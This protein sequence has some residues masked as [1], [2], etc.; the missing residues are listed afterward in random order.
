MR[1]LLLAGRLDLRVEEV[2]PPEPG[3][4]Q[5][6]VRVAAAGVCGSD[7]HGYRGT[8]DRR[9]PGTVMGHEVSGTVADVGP[10][11][12]P[13]WRGRPV[14]LNPVLGCERCPA[15]RSGEPQRCPDKAL[16]G[17]VPHL[18]GGFAE[19]V[20]GPVIALVPWDGPAPLAWGAFAE[21]LAVG[22]H[23]ARRL[24]PPQGPV[25]V[26]RP[27]LAERSVLVVGSGPVALAAAWSAQRDGARVSVTETDERRGSLVRSLGLA[28]QRQ[29]ALTPDDRYDAVVDCVAT[30]ESL[31]LALRQVRVA[32]AVVVVGLGAATAPLPVEL[33]V[34]RDLTLQGSAQYSRR[35][36]A[37]AVAWLG[38]GDLDVGPLLGTPE[39]LTAAPELFRTWDDGPSRPLRTLLTPG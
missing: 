18:P 6:V 14:A 29:D 24:V 7:L 12:D 16:I 19:L 9:R 33:L 17:C 26:Q 32:G 5:V 8:N 36:F 25:L 11:V 22:L 34:Q 13:G 39:P 1:R 30:E 28:T 35:S 27:V 31:G 20:V 2:A 4:G 23:A 38:S 21:P 10:G 3:A 37:D 15:C